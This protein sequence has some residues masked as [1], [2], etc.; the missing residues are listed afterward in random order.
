MREQRLDYELRC[1]IEMYRVYNIGSITNACIR[2][3]LINYL[4]NPQRYVD[5][6]M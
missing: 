4:D 6:I 2:M 5:N 1:N 3:F